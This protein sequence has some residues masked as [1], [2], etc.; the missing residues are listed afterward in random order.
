M[1]YYGAVIKNN[2]FTGKGI[3]RATYKGILNWAE[4]QFAKDETIT[5]EIRNAETF[6]LIK[7]FG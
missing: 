1:K 4:K 5:V 7:V 3:V 6:E 2:E